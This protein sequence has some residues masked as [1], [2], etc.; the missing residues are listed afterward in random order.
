MIK[1]ENKINLTLFIATICSILLLSIIIIFVS[2]YY[3]YQKDYK[4]EWI[5]LITITG[6]LQL[7]L[8]CIL[9]FIFRNKIYKPMIN[10]EK[11]V[12]KIIDSYNK[13]ENYDVAYNEN[14]YIDN[15]VKSIADLFQML[16][17]REY[18]IVLM[19]K[20]AELA[21][22]QSQINPHFLYNTLET[23]RG[24]AL[25]Y[26]MHDIANMTKALAD[27]FRYSISNKGNIISFKEE[28]QNIDSYIKIQQVRFNGRFI[29]EKSIPDYT[30]D[31]KMPKLLIQPIIENSFKHGI[32]PDTKKGI[33]TIE[34]YCTKDKFVITIK[35]NGVGMAITKLNEINKKLVESSYNG[36]DSQRTSIGLVNINERIRMVY[37][38][39]YGLH[40]YSAEGVGTT[41]EIVLGIYPF[42]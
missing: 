4:K 32:E 17:E 1:N 23:I 22:L 25:M 13:S 9:M 2:Y 38:K 35:D 18:S 34:A 19:K 3:L 5:I 36:D 33:I 16:L 26:N 12:N 40:L 30:L 7:I 6:V 15:K 10:I 27:I 8:F 37:G 20:Q 21:A 11:S 14:I 28:L 41:V 24:Q 29:F 39:D 42:N 31:I